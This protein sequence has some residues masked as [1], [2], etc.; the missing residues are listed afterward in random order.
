VL[1]LTA[2]AAAAHATGAMALPGDPPIV[3]LTPADGASVPA[4]P[5]AVTV[6]YLCPPY[7]AAVYDDGGGNVITDYRDGNDYRVRFATSP[8]L[9]SSGALA[10]EAFGGIRTPTLASDGTTCASE[11]SDYDGATVPAAIGRR[12]YWQA[13]RYCNGCTPQDEKGPVR[14]FVVRPTRIIAKLVAPRHLYAGYPALLAV[15]T[16]AKP[17]SADVL[18]QYRRQGKWVTFARHAFVT[19][20]TELIG[21]LPAGRHRLRAVLSAASYGQT[22]ARR[23][24]VVSRASSRRSTSSRDDGRYI[25]RNSRE[26]AK[27]TLSFRVTAGGGLLRDFKASVTTFC[28]GPTSEDNHLYVATALLRKVRIAPDG[29]IT[30][31]LATRG[32]RSELKLTGR[33]HHHRFRGKIE[34]QYS[35]CSGTRKLD[36]VR[37]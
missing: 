35:V 7:R 31:Y 30:G 14:S 5:G 37:R 8:A 29:S 25:A 27:S 6:T 36:A 34:A 26:R 19:D 32:Q 23:T 17:G 15:K 13:S 10:D 11:L 3:P 21:K 12:V 9:D 33:L 24:V 20:R 28:F 4:G 18:L 16:K 22:I 2:A 1:L